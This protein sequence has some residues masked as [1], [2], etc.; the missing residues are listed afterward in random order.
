MTTLQE[1]DS[2]VIKLKHLALNGYDAS[3]NVETRDGKAFVT[4]KADLGDI[5]Y[6]PHSQQVYR[7]KLSRSPSY[8]R[9]QERRR[10]ARGNR[11][12][13]VN[14]N[15]DVLIEGTEENTA[16]CAVKAQVMSEGIA[17]EGN[18][19][20]AVKAQVVPEVTAT[21]DIVTTIKTHKL[22]SSSVECVTCG[23]ALKENNAL[24]IH[25]DKYHGITHSLNKNGDIFIGS[26][27]DTTLHY[28]KTGRMIDVF[29]TYLDV[30]E[31]IEKSK[32]NEETKVLKKEKA[33]EA[34]KNSLG[35]IYMRFPPWRK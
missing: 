8:F 32:L 29:Q 21:E 9:R 20:S 4:L 33:L 19:G 12:S 16:G 18:V 25:N 1:I 2:F 3:L 14:R 22:D 5:K 17:Q 24:R 35:K 31:D 28:W 13:A 34:R 10:E 7:S 11:D 26:E 27:R 23:I 30:I 15:G 6:Y